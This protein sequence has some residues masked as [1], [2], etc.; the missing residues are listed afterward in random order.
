M[1]ERDEWRDMK[2]QCSV[3]VDFEREEWRDLRLDVVAMSL[4]SEDGEYMTS[5]LS[6]LFN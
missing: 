1:L 3:V 6:W 4:T 5:L 2:L